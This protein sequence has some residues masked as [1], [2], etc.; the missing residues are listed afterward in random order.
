MRAWTTARVVAD[1]IGYPRE[2]LHKENGLYLA[3]LDGILDVIVAQDVRFNNLMLF[4]HNPG[5]TDLVN[6]FV[7]GLTSNLPTSGVVSVN[8]ECDDWMLYD[9]P[10]A[11]LV[12][13]DY[14]KKHP[15]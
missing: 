14:P 13:H 6:Y 3:S 7:P 10:P 8:L 9:R 1:A 2:F 12:L 15:V 11:E 4:G 5:L